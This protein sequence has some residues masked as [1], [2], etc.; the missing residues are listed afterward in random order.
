MGSVASKTQDLPLGLV[1][2][3]FL[4]GVHSKNIRFSVRGN[5]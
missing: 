5:P 3:T 1:L 2:N 4:L